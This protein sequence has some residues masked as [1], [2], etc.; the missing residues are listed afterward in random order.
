MKVSFVNDD[1]I[2]TYRDC[3]DVDKLKKIILDCRNEIIS[4]RIE[5]EKLRKEEL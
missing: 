2:K 3:E 4:L 5:L 1:L